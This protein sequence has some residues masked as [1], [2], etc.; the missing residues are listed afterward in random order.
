MF[1]KTG[2]SILAQCDLFAVQHL[3]ESR[4][5]PAMRTVV[6]MRESLFQRKL[7][8]DQIWREVFE[9]VCNASKSLLPTFKI[10]FDNYGGY[11]LIYC[12]KEVVKPPTVFKPHPV[13]FVKVVPEGAVTDLS[14]MSSERTGE[15]LF[16]LGP[17][18]FVN[19][20]CQPNAE[21]DF[22]GDSGTVKLKVKRRISPGDEILVKYGD[23]FFEVNECNCRTC[24]LRR[25]EECQLTVFEDLLLDALESVATEALEDLSFED[26]QIE[27]LPNRTKRL[28]GLRLV[29]HYNE[30]NT[31]P[32]HCA[33]SQPL[34]EKKM[35]R[36][37][38]ETQLRTRKSD[39]ESIDCSSDSSDDSEESSLV[40]ELS[41]IPVE[42]SEPAEVDD[43]INVFQLQRVSSPLPNNDR[44]IDWVFLCPHFRSIKVCV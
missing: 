22:S 24:K 34:R 27:L 30:I 8:K 38:S 35:V 36:F 25:R 28:R 2:W 7:N 42:A 3:I 20:D 23:D 26:S 37:E 17:V 11:C 39:I 6:Q 33:S 21:F 1:K 5:R 12:G 19:S 43:E 13:G 44:T 32:E 9:T 16:L 4:E 14:V 41:E 10:T 18:R 15:Q 40:S 29:E 31:D